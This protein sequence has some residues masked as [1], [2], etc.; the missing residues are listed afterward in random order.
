MEEIKKYIKIIWI[1]FSSFIGLMVIFFFIVSMGWFVGFMPSFEELENPSSNLS[2]E[3]YSADKVLL[4]RYFIENRSNVQYNELSPNLINA[5]IATEDIRYY[6]HSGI[7]VR[8]L[9]RVF[10]KNVI[11]RNSDAGGGS[12]I[13]QQLAK[14]LFP[15]KRN[16]SKLELVIIKFK[17]WVTAVKLENNY[18]K[19]EIITMYLN[20]VE[21]G[22][23]SFGIKVAAKTFFNTSPD[24]LSIEEAAMLIGMLKGPTKYN[25]VMHPES[26]FNRRNIVLSQMYKY[27]F[28]SRED[29]DSI[30]QIPLNV[31]KYCVQDH[32]VGI[33]TYFREFLRGEL[34]KWCKENKNANGESYDLY[35]DGLKI[36]TTIDSRLQTHAEYAMT[37][38]I[39]EELQPSFYKHWKGVR[40]APFGWLMSEEKVEKFMN[41]AM[42]RSERY[43][44]LKQSNVSEDEITKS[45]HKK[46]KMKVF[47]WRGDLDTIMT[48]YDSIIYYKSFLQ[49]G[50]MSMNPKNGH[51]KA[52]VGGINHTHFKF[53]H[54][55]LAKRQVGSTFKPF[56]YALAMQEGESPCMKVRNVPVVINLGRGRT[57]SPKNSGKYKSGQYVT[58]KEGL[59]QSINNIS[60]WLI[61]RYSIN[62]VIRI[63]RKM[64]VKSE[65][66]QVYSISL[67][68]AE[69]NLFEMVGAKS[70]YVNHGIYSE[71]IFI[72]RIEDKNGNVIK[73][74]TTE[75]NEAISEETAY[76]M[77]ELMKGVVDAGTAKRLRYRYGFKNPIAGKTGT[78]QRNA[79]GWFIGLTPDLVTGV[80]VGC[81][82]IQIHFRSTGLG[83][84]ANTALPIWAYYMKEVYNDKSLNI[85]Q[86]DFDKPENIETELNCA[87]YRPV[88]EEVDIFDTDIM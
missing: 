71:P 88:R 67:G 13:S 1:I 36:Y 60:A 29:N 58:L 25:P 14:N 75:T 42:K 20:K 61:K 55:K 56:L 15:R 30:K 3:I 50:L 57:W 32:N 74:F 31:S 68:T 62:A 18:T 84:G 5:L 35:K 77:I 40:N 21:F 83:Q 46:L 12:T 73:E 47:S 82:D 59:A 63:A 6:S 11:L 34:K 66:P 4:G 44:K 10:W 79:D 38:Y 49:S 64:G 41:N 9:F 69:L 48:P 24:S 70:T 37:K 17:E 53:D 76:L 27:E 43:R 26:G 72:S 2:S 7:D 87:K 52:Y 16:R 78:T 33:A 39:G 80:W 22:G 8:G 19:E 51:V 86:G 81:E 28:L 23:N 54:V 65:I 45:F 85:S